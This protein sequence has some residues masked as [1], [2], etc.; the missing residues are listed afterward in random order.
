MSWIAVT[1]KAGKDV[2]CNIKMDLREVGC[3]W[4]DFI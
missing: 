1:A 2:N 3:M 4:I